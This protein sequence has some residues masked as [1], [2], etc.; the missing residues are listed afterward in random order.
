ML[1]QRLPEEV[2][3]QPEGRYAN[4]RRADIRI[5]CRDFQVPVEIKKDAHPNVW[6]ALRD[7]LIARYTRDPATGGCGIY[8]V[9][10]FGKSAEQR[11]RRVPP[12]PTGT[13]AR[14][15]GELRERL[16][17]TL[18][19]EEKRKITVCAMDVSPTTAVRKPL[20][21]L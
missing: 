9:L 15:P 1:R 18:T 8:L 5:S 7:Q 21:A 19:R 6:S 14:S 12:P 3:A 20:S 11:G 17:A 2:D 13:A 16:E 10:W 4:D